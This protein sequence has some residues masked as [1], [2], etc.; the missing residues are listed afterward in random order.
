MMVPV[1][2]QGGQFEVGIPKLIFE[3]QLST[4]VRSRV[5]GVGNGR[6][7]LVNMPISHSEQGSITVLLNWPALLKR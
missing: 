5:A 7:F 2:T 3:L 1:K 6:R 4:A